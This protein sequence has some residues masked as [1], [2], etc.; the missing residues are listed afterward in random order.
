[1]SIKV[2]QKMI[3]QEKLKILTPL[4]N[5]PKYVGNLG[6]LIVAKGFENCPKPNKSPSLLTLFA[7]QLLLWVEVTVECCGRLECC[8]SSKCCDGGML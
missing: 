7:T 3:S 2:A 6:N 8:G 4:Q 1:M 5:L